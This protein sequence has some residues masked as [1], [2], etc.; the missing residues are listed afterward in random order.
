MTSRWSS[1][2]LDPSLLTVLARG[3]RR[4]FGQTGQFIDAGPQ[5][6]DI[7]F[8]SGRVVVGGA[9]S[10][11]Q[12]VVTQEGEAG[13]NPLSVIHRDTAHSLLF[14]GLS[15]GVSATEDRGKSAARTFRLRV[16]V[17][18]DHAVLN[19]DDELA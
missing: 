11:A 17:E 2:L 7:A 4:Y 18:I 15:L 10:I 14:V 8:H 19:I 6:R 1:S 5:H 12:L 16:V 9:E 3:C 13:A